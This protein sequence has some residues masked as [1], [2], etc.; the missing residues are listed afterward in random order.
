MKAKLTL[1]TLVGLT[2]SS[3]VFAQDAPAPAAGETTPP[4]V[5]AATNTPAATPVA[6]E[7]VA[8]AVAPVEPAAVPDAPPSPTLA[9]ATPANIIPLIQFQDVPL[10]TAIDN[11][12]RQASINYILDPKVGYGQPDER[13]QI[14]TQPNIS[15]RWENLTAEQALHALI[16]T[17]GLQLVTDS[18]TGIARVT[19]KD[20]A[21]AEPLVT[22]VIQLKFASPSNTVSAVQAV[23]TD[24][25]SKVIADVRT[26]Q[27][28]ISAT[29]K[30]Q[31]AVEKLIE[32]LDTQTKQVLIE[33]KIL[34]TT[35]SPKTSK[36]I[37]WSGTVGAQ[38]VAF[39]NNVRQPPATESLGQPLVSSPIPKMLMTGGSF[40]PSTAFLDADGVAATI[41][42]LNTSGDTKV[43]SEPRMVT[44]DNQKATIDV[45]LM[46]PV[47]NVQ[48][49][50]ANTTGGSQISYTNLTINLDVT[51]RIAANNYIELRVQQGILRLG[52]TFASTVA[53]QNN[54][55]D[56]IL[57]RKLDTTVLIPSGNTLVMGGLI[58]DE[59]RTGNTKVPLLGDIPGIGLL[60][61]KDTKELDRQN[62][63]I[64]ITPT[65][66]EDTDFQPKKSTFLQST[67]SES[68]T[69]DWSWWDS[70]KPASEV[71]KD[72]E[73]NQH[74]FN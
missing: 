40:D 31:E 6:V 10:T 64:F 42:F 26:S 48:A 41:S 38:N 9:P 35:L 71:A 17:Y 15:I 63:T 54:V 34:E 20:P 74:Q 32:R 25:R 61:R 8:A 29:E 53:G 59:N 30:E 13:G 14:K 19:V 21:A 23:L 72:K 70:G 58:Q 43:V 45:G 1:L 44:L 67:G 3:L 27:L 11:L 33:A 22:K 18:K 49:S 62:L 47:V 24:K 69:E 73:K 12:A 52:P 68:V 65:V 39:G 56:S 4:A 51:P 7:P 36:G 46:Y 2:T 37:D 55:V 66:V 28:V 5:E 16:T 57:T 60:F 50:T